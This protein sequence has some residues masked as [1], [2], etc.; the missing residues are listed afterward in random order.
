MRK[1]VKNFL[2]LCNTVFF[3]IAAIWLYKSNYDY[4]P[5]IALGQ[6]L[7]TLVVL[8]VGDSVAKNIEMSRI[9]KSKVDIDKDAKASID[10]VDDSEITIK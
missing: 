7:T 8:F 4:E 5:M 3:V 1:S 10:K 9:R 6:A 2:I